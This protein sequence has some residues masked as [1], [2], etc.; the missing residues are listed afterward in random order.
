MNNFRYDELV[1]KALI[2][3]VRDVLKDVSENGLSG[4]HHFY[5][6]FRTDHPK[7]R[8]PSFL[9]EKH[10]EEI[11]VVIQYQFWNLKVSPDGFSIDLSFNGVQ[12]NLQIPFSAMTA[13]VDPSVKFALQFT[14]S[15]EEDSPFDPKK[16]SIKNEID[17]DGKIIS[18]D[19]FRKK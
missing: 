11:M 6:R 10:P 16:E 9:K 5:V 13:F 1:Q 18:F 19:S 12:E 7:V 8:I 15:F 2:S 4:S 17:C 3:V 14:P